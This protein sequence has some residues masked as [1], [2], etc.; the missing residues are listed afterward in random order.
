ML[1]NKRDIYFTFFFTNID[2]RAEHVTMAVKPIPWQSKLFIQTYNI[3]D[4]YF[5]FFFTNIDTRAEHV[6]MAVKPIPWQSKLF[7]Q[8]YNISDAI[9]K[10]F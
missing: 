10:S 2:T 4:I 5:T 3:S 8:T 6:T 7:I 9:T 1:R